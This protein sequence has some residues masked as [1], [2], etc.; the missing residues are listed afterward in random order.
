MPCSRSGIRSATLVP[1]VAHMICQNCGARCELPTAAQRV[2][3]TFC[4]CGG[5]CQVVRVVRHPHI[6]ASASPLELE[7]TF[8]ARASDE[9]LTP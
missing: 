3:A 9:T 2:Q 8:Q 5:L 7:R 6:D 1:V 4:S